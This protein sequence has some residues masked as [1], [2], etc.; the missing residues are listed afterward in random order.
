MTGLKRERMRGRI[1][2]SG[3]KEENT[4]QKSKTTEEW[5]EN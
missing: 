1:K 2:R 5:E 4:E 3:G